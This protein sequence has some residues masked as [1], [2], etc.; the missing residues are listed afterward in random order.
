MRHRE[1]VQLT[2]R[3]SDAELVQLYA[4]AQ[5]CAYVPYFEGFGIPIVEAQASGCPVITSNTSSMPEV[6]GPNGALLVDPFDVA[7]ITEALIQLDTDP[8]LR[9]RLIAGGLENVQRFSWN[10]SADQL[11][12]VLNEESGT[13]K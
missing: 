7:D 9:Q 8:S 13:K 2:G 12:A 6:A 5:A 10:Q 3:V 1:A 11:Y 4:A